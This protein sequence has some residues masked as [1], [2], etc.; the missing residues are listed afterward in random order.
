MGMSQKPTPVPPVWQFGSYGFSLGLVPTNTLAV[1]VK[2]LV[3]M[4]A[5]SAEHRKCFI[6]GRLQRVVE[7]R[8]LEPFKAAAEGLI[9]TIHH[10]NIR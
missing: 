9:G 6:A 3:T 7:R 8:G 4:S 5:N 1:T 2:L 10:N